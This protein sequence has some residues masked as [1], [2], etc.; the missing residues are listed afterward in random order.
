MIQIGDTQFYVN[1]DVR[2]KYSIH[3]LYCF[4]RC[5]LIICSISLQFLHSS[6]RFSTLKIR[7]KRTSLSPISGRRIRNFFTIFCWSPRRS[8]SKCCRIVSRLRIVKS[9]QEFRIF[10]PEYD[11]GVSIQLNFLGILNTSFD[12]K[13]WHKSIRKKLQIRFCF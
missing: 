2:F 9:N 1:K 6:I 5:Q 10:K 11:F 3:L 8:A 7:R 13:F 12:L 4:Y